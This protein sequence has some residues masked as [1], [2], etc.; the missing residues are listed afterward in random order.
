MTAENGGGSAVTGEEHI[1]ESG[2]MAEDG[3]GSADVFSEDEASIG[4]DGQD[5]EGGNQPD[6]GT[7]KRKA[8]P[9]PAAVIVPPARRARI[10]YAKLADQQRRPRAA[11]K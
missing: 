6:G 1:E 9:I 7:R 10:D 8:N 4:G 2:Q 3:G 5:S 11:R